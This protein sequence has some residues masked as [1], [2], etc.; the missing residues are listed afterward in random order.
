[1]AAIQRNEI[2]SRLNDLRILL[3][4]TWTEDDTHSAQLASYRGLLA[5]TFGSADGQ[6][7]L[8]D[9]EG[10]EEYL[11]WRMSEHSC[12][13]RIS[14]DT[15]TH[16]TGLCWLSHTVPGLVDR[17]QLEGQQV[18]FH[19]S[20][21]QHSMP[22]GVPIQEIVGSVIFQLL[23]LKSQILRDRRWFDELHRRLKM[24]SWSRDLKFVCQTLVMVLEEF[25]VTNIIL[26]RIDRAVCSGKAPRFIQRLL[27][28]LASSR[29][30]TRILLVTP[31]GTEW[32]MERSDDMKRKCMYLDIAQLNE[33]VITPR[34]RK[35][36]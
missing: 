31:S 19:L 6:N 24:D 5:Q 1:M 7:P 35:R 9:L 10:M 14:G 27:E 28:T 34:R 29:C 4:P 23:Q 18:I 32:D 12:I 30:H 26:D 13:L 17:L 3:V 11:K 36:H 16:H 20:Q 15:T 2:N 8:S 21:R 25:E 33:E 22:Y